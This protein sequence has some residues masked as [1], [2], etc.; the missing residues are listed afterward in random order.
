M[1]KYIQLFKD[2]DSQ[3]RTVDDPDELNEEVKDP[4]G[5]SQNVGR[6][7]SKSKAP[8]EAIIDKLHQHVR[9]CDKIMVCC[10]VC[11]DLVAK[12]E[13]SDHFN[14]CRRLS[15]NLVKC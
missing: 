13:Y 11:K 6:P 12:S 10:P 5:V 7:R 3:L 8:L 4:S 14:N 9:N 15:K 1:R 2:I